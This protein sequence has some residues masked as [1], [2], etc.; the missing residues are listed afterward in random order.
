MK[1]L[2]VYAHHE[3]GS[4]SAA[5]LARSIETL[6]AE[7]HEVELSD[8]YG[9][10]FNPLAT[11]EDFNA[12][13]FPELLQYDREQKNAWQEGRL[14]ADIAAELEKVL[15]CDVLIL[16]FPL[17]WFSVPAI[18]KG[19]IDRVFVHSVAYGKGMR[20]DQGGF[21]GRRAM[22]VMT[23]GCQQQ[24]AQPDG[25]IG[26]L[27]VMLYHLHAGTLAYTGFSVLPPF[28]AYS[29]HYCDD[30]ARQRYLDDYAERLRTLDTLTPLPFQKLSDFGDDWRLLPEAE[31]V[32]A[33]HRHRQS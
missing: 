21:R 5:L 14:A 23:T 24:M 33:G 18:M 17:W 28:C 15:R 20:L 10:A 30:A 9:M 2:I 1:F 25:L 3:P 8:L 6:R 29:I 22:L 4:F 11:A 13:R 26:D 19:W 12:R 31:A 27:E 16:Q 32:D 7:G